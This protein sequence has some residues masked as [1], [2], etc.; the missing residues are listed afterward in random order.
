MPFFR[1]C[2][3][4]RC[5]VKR[6]NLGGFAGFAGGRRCCSL[7]LIRLRAWGLALLLRENS[8]MRN[9]PV[10]SVE[11]LRTPIFMSTCQRQLLILWNFEI[12]LGSFLYSV[13]FV[14]CIYLNCVTNQTFCKLYLLFNVRNIFLLT[15]LTYFTNHKNTIVLTF[16]TRIF[17]FILLWRGL[18]SIKLKQIFFSTHLK[19]ICSTK[20]STD[21]IT[22]NFSQNS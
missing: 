16:I 6:N 2:H 4:R 5:S 14:I 19:Q 10:G 12:L 21:A 11:F 22:R 7:F 1:S 8:S 18:K 20:Y 9:F 15:L 13:S 17:Y 3:H